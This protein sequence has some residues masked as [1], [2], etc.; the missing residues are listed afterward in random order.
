MGIHTGPATLDELIIGHIA[1]M[2][3][4]ADSLDESAFRFVNRDAIIRRIRKCAAEVERARM[5]VK[6]REA[7]QGQSPNGGDATEIVVPALLTGPTA[8]GGD[9][10]KDHP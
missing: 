6:A 2:R 3:S 5:F 8:E 9:A 10:R 7:R 1:S 4:F